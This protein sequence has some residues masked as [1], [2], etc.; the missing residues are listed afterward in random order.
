MTDQDTGDGTGQG[1]GA[2]ASPVVLSVV[3]I[4]LLV[5]YLLVL[6]LLFRGADDEGASETV[7]G[8]YIFLLGGLEAV[9]FTAVGW[10]FGREVNRRQ[11]NQAE[12]ATK[13]AAEAKAKGEGLRQAI[14]SHPAIGGDGTEAVVGDGSMQALR[15]QAKAT[16]F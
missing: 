15:M 5:A 14:L 10:L 9:V 7:W 2:G 16:R 1:G 3:A 11:A 13:E 6:L 12:Q 8:R 4:G